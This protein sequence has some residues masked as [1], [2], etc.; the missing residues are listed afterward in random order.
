MKYSAKPIHQLLQIVVFMLFPFIGNGQL[1]PI[2]KGQFAEN[3]HTVIRSSNTELWVKTPGEARLKVNEIRTILNRES[4]GNELVIHYNNFSKVKAISGTIYNNYGKVV[5]K[6][7][8][9]D[10]EDY[11]AVSGYTIYSDSRV[12]YIEVSHNEY[13]YTV[14][15]NY[16]I[17]YTGIRD[18]RDWVPQ[19]SAGEAVEESSYKV[20]MPI[21]MKLRYKAVNTDLQ[22]VIKEEKGLKSYTWEIKDLK[23]F[24]P[25][26]FCPSEA[27]YLPRVHLAPSSF[28]VDGYTGDMSTW[29]TFGQFIYELNKG[30]GV[31]S[32]EMQKKVQEMVAEKTTDKEKIVTLYK[33]LQENSRYVSV[34]LGIGGWQTF[35][36]KYVEQNKYGDCKALTYFMNS[37]LEEAGIESYPA[38]ILSSNDRPTYYQDFSEPQ[39]NHVIL[40]VPE[41][42]LW[43]ECTSKNNPA[44]YLGRSCQNRKALLIKPDDSQLI[45]APKSTAATNKQKQKIKVMLEEN[46]AANVQVVTQCEGTQQDQIRY[47]A[48]SK[49]KED[50][51][52][53]LFEAIG[54]SGFNLNSFELISDEN[55]PVGTIS[56]EVDVQKLASASGARLFIYPNILNRN[57]IVPK[58][59][60]DRQFPVERLLPY[61]DEDVVEIT[62]PEGYTIENLPDESVEYSTDFGTYKANITQVG[63]LLTY[64][65]VFESFS[66]RFP[67]DRYE[68]LR[69][70]YK[71]V[72]KA[73][74]MKIALVKSK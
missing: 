4:E 40:Y 11:S 52:K 72:V 37:L 29:K 49:S 35:P 14:A 22:P 63:N 45:D 65:R 66:F 28:F 1:S 32:N 67:A 17:E 31:L 10:I 61:L 64:R 58:K 42:D 47:L 41:E 21:E 16:E 74:K 56:Y 6:I 57:S 33:Y 71:Q 50:Q 54:L 26:Y 23:S 15:F 70:F 20:I 46:G 43:L 27:D 44:N 62:I 68:D 39:F 12:K 7:G 8:K 9:S 36:A 24:E 13:P 34:Q 69:K 53:W 19:Y 55:K 38:L 48:N 59:V 5:R 73:D 2:V 18:Y 3:T 30:R 51:E 60:E 25:E